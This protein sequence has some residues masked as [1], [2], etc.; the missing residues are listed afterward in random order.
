M[1]GKFCQLGEGGVVEVEE[2]GARGRVGEEAG[3]AGGVAGR[4]E[5][6]GLDGR[7]RREEAP[8]RGVHDLRC[9]CVCVCVCAWVAVRLGC[10]CELLEVRWAFDVESPRR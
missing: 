4:E 1:R 5:A 10:V 6:L 9:G 3:E 2:L 8:G 7:R